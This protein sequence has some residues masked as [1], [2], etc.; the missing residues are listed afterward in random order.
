MEEIKLISTV[1]GYGLQSLNRFSGTL[2]SRRV[3]K[4]VALTHSNDLTGL[5]LY[6][7]RTNAWSLERQT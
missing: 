6:S 1:A 7:T 3:K 5:P 2:L 4:S